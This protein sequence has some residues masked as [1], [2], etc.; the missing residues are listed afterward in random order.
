[1]KLSKPLK[2]LIGIGTAI[3]TISPFVF[4]MIWLSFIFAMPFFDLDTSQSFPLPLLALF[5]LAFP[6]MIITSFVQLALQV[7]YWSH[8]ILNKGSSEAGKIL[9]GIG[10]FILPWLAMP[11]YFFLHVVPDRADGGSPLPI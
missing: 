10:C 3:T 7:F 4:P 5:L 6:M 2:V 11:I 9:F 8:I 1:M